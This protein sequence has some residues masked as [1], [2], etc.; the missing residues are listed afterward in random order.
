MNVAPVMLLA[1]LALGCDGR[2]KQQAPNPPAPRAVAA[3]G[4]PAIVPSAVV[5][6]DHGDEDAHGEEDA[7][8][9]S[10]PPQVATA[11]ALAPDA[12][13]KLTTLRVM[14]HVG[15]VIVRKEQ[16]EWVVGGANGCRVP[17]AR[18]E[19][20][21]DNL[22]SLRSEPTADRPQN[23]AEFELQVIA[24]IGQERALHFDMAGRVG[25]RDLVQLG[26]YSTYWISGFDRALWTPDARA[27]CTTP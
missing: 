22:A 27:W 15:A 17:Q 21:L 2:A 16:G 18:I 19:S 14:A 1:S 4:T 8:P 3:A 5:E 10:S 7:H 13:V 9:P 11:T 26:D 6:A 23:G 24:Q 25:E 12:R 20:A